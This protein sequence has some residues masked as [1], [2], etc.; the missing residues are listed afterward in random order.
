M[1]YHAKQVYVFSNIFYLT[2]DWITTGLLLICRQI[3][4]KKG[5]RMM[6]T[7]FFIMFSVK[8]RKFTFCPGTLV[9]RGLSGPGL[10]WAWGL[11]GLGLK[12]AGA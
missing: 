1:T 5:P 7:T 12:W 6:K 10:K 11:S 3:R 2:S 4:S 9:G 8:I